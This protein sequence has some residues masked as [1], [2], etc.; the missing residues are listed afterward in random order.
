MSNINSISVSLSKSSLSVG[1]RCTACV[2]V[3]PSNAEYSVDWRSGDSWVASVSP[4]GVVYANCPGTTGIH[5]FV[6]DACGNELH[7]YAWIT[8]TGSC[9]GSDSGSDSETVPVQSVTVCP[10]SLEIPRAGSAYLNAAVYPENATD[11]EIIWYSDNCCVADVNIHGLV[12][13]NAVG[14]ATIYAISHEKHSIRAACAV[15][16]TAPV[17]V[18]RIEITAPAESIDCLG[19]LQLTKT[20]YPDN[21]TLKNVRSCRFCG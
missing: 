8:V 9:S 21:A 14:N 3:S 5:A 19:Q 12:V 10:T 1:E 7:A 15:T 20:V 18:E 2:Q 6:T 13:G 16:V 17:L 4:L 11:K